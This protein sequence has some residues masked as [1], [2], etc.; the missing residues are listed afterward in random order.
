MDRIFKVAWSI[1]A[2]GT[3]FKGAYVVIADDEVHAIERAKEELGRE[4]SAASFVVKASGERALELGRSEY[5]SDDASSFRPNEVLESRVTTP[6]LP[7]ERFVFDIAARANVIASDKQ[8]AQK[9]LGHALAGKDVS[10]VKFLNVKT[11]DDPEPLSGMSAY[12]K[13]LIEKQ[14]RSVRVAST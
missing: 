14:Y 10:S 8:D 7:R 11:C 1:V 6:F 4:S 13:M 5:P 3:L 9:K 2:D 12:E